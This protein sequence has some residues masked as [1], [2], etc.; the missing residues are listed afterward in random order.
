M[1]VPSA[2]TDLA[3]AAATLDRRAFLRLAAMA[4]STAMPD[5]SNVAEAIR[6]SGSKE[7]AG[8]LVPLLTDHEWPTRIQAIQGLAD[9]DYAAAIP[10]IRACLTDEEPQ[11]RSSAAVALTGA[12]PPNGFAARR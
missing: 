4:T 2:S 8:A 10:D 9:L 7:Y 11:V 1:S 6:R 12:V 5:K 3:R